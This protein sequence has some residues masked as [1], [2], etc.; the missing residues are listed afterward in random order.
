[1]LHESCYEFVNIRHRLAKLKACSCLRCKASVCIISSHRYL[2]FLIICRGCEASD[3]SRGVQTQ[4]QALTEAASLV[5]TRHGHQEASPCDLTSCTALNAAAADCVACVAALWL[6]RPSLADMAGDSHDERR[7]E[8][9]NDQWLL[10]D[11][12]ACMWCGGLSTCPQR[13]GECRAP[14][15]NSCPWCVRHSE[16]SSVLLY[17]D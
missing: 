7:S 16:F 17:G 14:L 2:H 11:V 9:A 1:V 12:V 10:P 6:A 13:C 15:C 3:P 4:S 8:G 5:T